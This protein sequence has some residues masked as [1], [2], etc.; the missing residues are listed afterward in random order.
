MHFE[1]EAEVFEA[2]VAALNDVDNLSSKLIK[3]LKEV[4]T[5]VILRGLELGFSPLILAD[6]RSLQIC[7][8]YYKH[9]LLILKDA[10]QMSATCILAIES[11]QAK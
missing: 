10:L 11:A 2:L 6:T 3:A 7:I 1:D 8:D 4:A 9:K 5:F